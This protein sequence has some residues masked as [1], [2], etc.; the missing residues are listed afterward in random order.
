MA[1]LWTRPSAATVVSQ[2]TTSGQ[3][4]ACPGSLRLLEG[5][6]RRGI[7]GG[8]DLSSLAAV[9]FPI[10]APGEPTC[11]APASPI[12]RSPI[13]WPAPDLQGTLPGSSLTDTSIGRRYMW[14]DRCRPPKDQKVLFQ[15]TSPQMT[16]EDLIDL[17]LD[18][19]ESARKLIV[20]QALQSGA[21]KRSQVDEVISQVG[22]LER[23][24]AMPPRK[25]PT[26]TRL[27]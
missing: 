23:A 22:R 2:P 18:A 7:G 20:F 11:T 24:V 9:V 15:K 5:L 6:V 17:L 8:H 12:Y 25:K 21:L 10:V 13:G 14:P 26:D 16:Q 1:E 3:M 27:S 4:L 19:D